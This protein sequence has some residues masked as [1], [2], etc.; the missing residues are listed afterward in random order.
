M[1]KSTAAD[2]MR[3]RGFALIDTDEIA[4]E[5]VKPGTAAL[6]EIKSIFGGR[7]VGLNGELRRRELAEVVFSDAEARARLENI[8]HPQIRAIWKQ[9]VAEWRSAQLPCGAVVIPLLFETGAEMEFDATIAVG[10]A[11]K[12]QAERLSARGWNA[13]EIERRIAS[14][15]SSETKMARAD[16]VIWSEGPLST[17]ERQLDR[18]LTMAA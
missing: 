6:E 9:K 2:I 18:I 14:Q 4:R 15:L 17:H 11:S 13:I 5:L 3:K 1:G 12:T 16:F 7:F 8:L 10:C